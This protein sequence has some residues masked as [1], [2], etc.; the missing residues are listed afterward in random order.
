[1]HHIDF[2]REQIDLA[3][4]HGDGD[5]AGLDVV[6]LCSERLFAVCSP[7]LIQGRKRVT[8]ASDLLK[9]PLLRLDGWDT[10]SRWFD[11]AGISDPIARGPVLS[12]ASMLIDAAVDG[13]GSHLHEPRLQHGISST[14]G[15]WL[16]SMSP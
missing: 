7:K 13:Q 10:W 8:E 16:Q 9:F 15:L 4:R 11:A 3:V 14:A 12:Q 1:M 6:R 2:A 5:W